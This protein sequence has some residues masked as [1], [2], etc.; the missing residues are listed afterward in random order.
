[1]EVSMVRIGLIL[2]AVI[3]MTAPARSNDL[4]E[5]LLRTL[6]PCSVL[7]GEDGT[8]W[9][10]GGLGLDGR[11]WLFKERVRNYQS[12]EQDDPILL[13][14]RITRLDHPRCVEGVL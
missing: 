6:P 9:Y 11:V 14:M 13:G 5:I 7:T 8:T 3:F 12:F 10:F 1:M 4:P 2:A